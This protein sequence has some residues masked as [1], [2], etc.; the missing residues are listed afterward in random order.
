MLEV[1]TGLT[2]RDIISGHTA[3]IQ[4]WMPYP[5]MFTFIRIRSPLLHSKYLIVALSDASAG[6]SSPASKVCGKM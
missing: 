4:K 6:W 2:A 3:R 5:R 1:G